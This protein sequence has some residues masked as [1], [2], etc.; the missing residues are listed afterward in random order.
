MRSDDPKPKSQFKGERKGAHSNEDTNEVDNSTAIDEMR[1]PASVGVRVRPSTRE[2]VQYDGE[3]AKR[4]QERKEQD[5]E[6]EGGERD[7]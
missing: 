4:S 1:V 3:G 5:H 2:G 7:V 6:R